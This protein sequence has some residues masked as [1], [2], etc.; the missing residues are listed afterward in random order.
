M[1]LTGLRAHETPGGFEVA[2]CVRRDLAEIK[3][4]SS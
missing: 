3:A 2:G 4:F 1:A